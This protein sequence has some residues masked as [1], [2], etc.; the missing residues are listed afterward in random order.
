M[1]GGMI[2]SDAT[3]TG[4]LLVLAI[5]LPVVGIL[6]ALVLGGRHAERI[7]LVLLP[8]GFAIAA[9]VFLIVREGG[10]ALVYN[11]GGWHPPLGIALRADGLAAAMMVTTAIIISATALFAHG[12]FSQPLGSPEAR[13]PFVFWI[14]LLAIWSA[15]NIVVL[16]RDLFNLYVALELLTFA[17]VPLVCLKGHKD[18]IRAAL[19]Y[20]IFAL[21]GSVLYLLGTA[22]LYGAYGTLD[23]TL[24]SSRARPE[25]LAWTATA[26]MTTGLLAK[27][28]L[29][30]FHFWLPPAHAGA[31]PAGSAV[32]SA[33]VVKGAFFLIVRLWFD[34]MPGVL[35]LAAAQLLATLGAAAILFGSV[36][37]MRQQRLKLLVAY[38]TVAQIG[39]LFFIF[40]L[41]GNFAADAAASS[42]AWTGGWLQLFSHAFAKAA[43]FMAAGLIAEALG[44]DRIADLGGIG[45]ALPVTVLTFGLAGLSLMGVPPSGGFKAKW[46]LL[47]AS[48]QE[49]QWWWALVMLAGGLLAGGYVFIVLGKALGGARVPC[50][51]CMKVSRS[52]E[53]VALTIA[54]CAVLLGL[55]PLEPSRLL[56]I[57]RP[58]ALDVMS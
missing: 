30:P 22:I 51:L 56:Q 55:L 9:A 41:A 40:P 28:A 10:T 16:G 52:R 31:P 3:A 5:M 38:S 34:A 48:A 45:R 26:L 8:V 17:A 53:I 33:L 32:L 50:K 13:A 1:P 24:L 7:A 14:L 4:F 19:R 23:L 43:M 36:V 54:L 27:A 47:S 44:H 20:L 42:I 37:A 18:T 6:F 15:M 58:A 49:G 21:C 35:N 29:F 12:E 46:V 39:Y 2:P 11:V 25:P 57:G